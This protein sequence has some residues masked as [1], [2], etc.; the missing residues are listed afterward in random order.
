M[1]KV[2]K[3]V[4][5][6]FLTGLVAC[7]DKSPG[8]PYMESEQNTFYI[9]SENG[10]DSNLGLSEQ[11]P[12]KSLSHLA[13][14][15]LRP[16][17]SIRFKRGSSFVGPLDIK[18]SGIAGKYI[19]LT[20]YGAKTDAAPAFTNPVFKQ[21]NFGNCI[22]LYGKY[23][24]V[25][26]LYFHHTAAYVDASGFYT[27]D[28]GWD[29][30]YMGAVFIAVGAKN[31][32]I[33]NNEMFD[34]VAG[35]RSYGEGAL[36]EGN[37]IHDC[38]RPLKMWNWGPKGIWL[39]GDYQTVRNNRIF[40]MICMDARM[41]SD[42]SG[43]GAFEIDDGRYL[44]SHILISHNYTRGNHGFLEVVF[45]DVVADPAY[46]NFI[47]T[48]NVADDYQS[49]VKLRKSRNCIVDNNTIVRR[50]KNTN[51]AGVFILKD[52]NVMDKFR[53]NIVVMAAGVR[54]WA[55]NNGNPNITVQNNLFYSLGSS[56]DYG[57]G[58][59][60]TAAI[61]GDPGFTDLGLENDLSGFTLKQG[62]PAI[63][64]GVNLGY[65]T[66]IMGNVLSGNPDLGAIEY[67]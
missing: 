11:Q 28:G 14:M 20:D 64:T 65:D 31:C 33:R 46:E 47:I 48:Y 29:V 26:N 38:N 32:V 62:S 49:F 56:V 24:L 58:N 61:I 25:E 17:D 63:D 54:V 36:I 55:F 60:G 18:Q 7:G 35:V 52:N 30:W 15:T 42:G 16:G 2:L 21:D 1:R 6:L 23:I 9:D 12:W 45:N 43:G 5:F 40:N 41:L 8:D 66:D 10:D 57:D 44:K 27:T 50:R 22:R 39:G 34:C 67:K 19:T 3:I 53:N 13:E 59:Q 51:E 4:V 37:Y